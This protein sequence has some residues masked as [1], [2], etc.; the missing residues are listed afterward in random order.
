ILDVSWA[1]FPHRPRGPSAR[2]PSTALRGA[3]NRRRDMQRK[4]LALLA[5]L[6]MAAAACTTGD[7][8]ADTVP[9]TDTDGTTA[10]TTPP[11]TGDTGTTDTTG[12]AVLPQ[13]EGGVLAAVQDRGTVRCGVND[14]LPGFG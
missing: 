5:V 11:D 3:F 4:L 6:A 14:V 1:D 7:P 8:S 9:V 2:V 10:E 13:D 12:P